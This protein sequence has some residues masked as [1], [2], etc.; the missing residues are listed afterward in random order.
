M[1][2]SLLR[3]DS[4]LMKTF[5]SRGFLLSPISVK[6]LPIEIVQL[7][8]AISTFFQLESDWL[9]LPANWLITDQMLFVQ[10]TQS[11]IYVTLRMEI[12]AGSDG[13]GIHEFELEPADVESQ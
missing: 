2:A 7:I 11:S 10:S 12:T 13:D 3:G 8:R 4:A 1:R 5:L 9:N 6:A